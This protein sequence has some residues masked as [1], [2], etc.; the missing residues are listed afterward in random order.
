MFQTWNVSAHL[1]DLFDAFGAEIMATEPE[2]SA[3]NFRSPALSCGAQGMAIAPSFKRPVRIRATQVSC[4]VG[5]SPCRRVPRP[6]LSPR[7]R[8]CSRGR[9]TGRSRGGVPRRRSEPDHGR[10]VLRGPP[11]DHITPEVEPLRRLPVEV[12][13]S[14]LVVPYFAKVPH[15]S[16]KVAL[17]TRIVLKRFARVMTYCESFGSRGAS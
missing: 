9:K 11:V 5:P 12:C 15:L 16:P 3:L 10:P 14:L 2:C 7:W 6:T 8:T 4:R 1:L 13:V 17:R